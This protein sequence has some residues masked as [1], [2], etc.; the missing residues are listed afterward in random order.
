MVLMR[1][2]FSTGEV[3]ALVAE[4]V[5]QKLS[6]ALSEPHPQCFFEVLHQATP[7][8]KSLPSMAALQQNP[9]EWHKTMLALQTAAI[10]K[11][12]V[13]LSYAL[14]CAYLP[15]PYKICTKTCVCQDCFRCRRCVQ[16][17]YPYVLQTDTL[18]AEDVLNVLQRCDV[19]RR[20]ETLQAHGEACHILATAAELPAPQAAW[21]HALKHACKWMWPRF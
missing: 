19:W 3:D 18:Q 20:P 11:R 17:A 12:P 1:S 21:Q 5:W 8:K 14:M 13:S 2:M 10:Q 16:A 6:R 7:W 4:R 9:P 15:P